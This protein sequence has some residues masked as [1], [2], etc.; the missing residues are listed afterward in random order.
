MAKL[1]IIYSKSP[2][3]APRDL[4]LRRF[5]CRATF[6]AIYAVYPQRHQLAARV[7]AF[8]DFVALSLLQ[9]AASS[10]P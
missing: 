4:P 10:K 6:A 5:D 9:Q 3:H 8:V 2:R 1:K 7:R